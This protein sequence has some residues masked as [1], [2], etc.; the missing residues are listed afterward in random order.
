[1]DN[2]L[3]DRLWRSLK[4]ECVDLHA[5]ETGSELR[6]GLARWIGDYTR[7]PHSTLGGH[8]PD[9]GYGRRRTGL[10]LLRYLA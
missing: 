4:H 3:I 8:T 5:F 1:M 10:A 2:V 7:R 9:E 6:A